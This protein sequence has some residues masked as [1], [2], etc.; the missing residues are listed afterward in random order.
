LLSAS[1]GESLWKRVDAH[2]KAAK[3]A[4]EAALQRIYQ[5]RNLIAHAGDRKG[6][7]RATISVDE[8]EADLACV[9]SIVAALDDLT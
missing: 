8:V 9:L 1:W 2:R 3:G 4:S 5:R 7:G 6:H